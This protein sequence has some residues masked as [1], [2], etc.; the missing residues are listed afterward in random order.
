[1]ST[2]VR[3]TYT[4]EQARDTIAASLVAGANVTITPND[5]ADTIT[6]SAATLGASGIPAS[7]VDAK[8]DLIAATANDT[9]AR[10]AVGADGLALVANSANATG[11]GY[12]API[13]AAHSH[14]GTELILNSSIHSA[15]YT[16]TAADMGIEQVYTGTTAGTFT[17]PSDT[18]ASI[19]AGRSAP[20]HQAGTG[21]LTIAGASGVTVVARGGALKMA[22]QY[23]VAELRKIGSNSW[24]LYGDITP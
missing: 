22:G 24:L 23:A 6:I 21:Q 19:S 20:L 3:T 9:V 16:L 2:T 15:S 1:M 13:P 10:M 8:G 18:T 7:T 4:A 11:L 14:D 12:A 5:G 17:V